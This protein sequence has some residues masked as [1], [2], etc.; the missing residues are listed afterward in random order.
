MYIEAGLLSR[1]G[2]LCALHL[3]DRRIAIISDERVALAIAS[4]IDRAHFTFPS[5]EASK[6]RESWA[7]L[8]DALLDAGFGRDSAIV[9]LGGGVTGDLAGFVAATYLRGIPWLQVPTTLLAMLDASVGGKTGV[10]TPAGK[11]LV[12]AFHQPVAVVMDPDVLVSLPLEDLRNGLAEAVKHA[13]I[14]D[15]DHFAWLGASVEQILARKPATIELLLRRNVGIKAS[16]VQADEREGGRRAI[17]NAGHTIGHAVEHASEFSLSHGEAVA[18][19]LVSEARLGERL[20]VT[21]P[22]TA[23][24]LAS[25]LQSFGLPVRVPRVLDVEVIVTALRNDKKNRA[26]ELRVVLLSTIGA[27]NG[28]ESYGWTVAVPESL[29]RESLNG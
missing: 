10:D 13:A 19:G 29:V 12:G 16:V 26:N 14:L 27:I 8:T 4:P 6:S 18:I 11:N 1:L 24:R 22:G 23:T 25:L 7:K 21:E 20:G 15:A 2:E 9:S 17:L 3:P 28:S 5:G